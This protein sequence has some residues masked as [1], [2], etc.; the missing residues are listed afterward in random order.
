[1]RSPRILVVED[2]GLQAMTLEDMLEDLGCEVAASLGTVA[3]ALAWLTAGDA[4]DGALL[5]VSLDGQLVYPVAEILAERGVP[6]AFTSGY[7]Q[8]GERRFG[9]A[10]ALVKPVSRA[11]L[12]RALRGF[13]LA[14]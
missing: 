6:F 3:E 5:D 1:M 12:L 4:L 10:P 2:E 11:T 8:L 7:G 13:G 14:V 9:A